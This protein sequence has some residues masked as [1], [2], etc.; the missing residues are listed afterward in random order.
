MLVTFEGIDGCGKSTLARKVC[1]SISG[2]V[3][4]T[5]E[6]TR[7][8]TSSDPVA[9][10]LLFAADRAEHTSEL[11]RFLERGDILCDRYCDSTSAFQGVM[12]SRAHNVDIDE[13][14]EYLAEVHMPFIIP[15]DK[16][17]Y[18][19]ISVEKAQKRKKELEVGFLGDVREAYLRMI[20][21]DPLNRESRFIQL[22]GEETIEK[23]SQQ[24]LEY[25]KPV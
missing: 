10:A 22:D 1:E 24:V 7:E 25:L 11:K 8:L 18:I 5:H 14:F 4:L 16:T 12:I 6:P 20:E 17:F 3:L 21:K 23:L 15:P 19:D 2:D 13:V 9:L